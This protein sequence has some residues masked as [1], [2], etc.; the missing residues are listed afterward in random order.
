MGAADRWNLGE[1]WL[2]VC[3]PDRPDLEHFV[4]ACIDGGVDIVQLREKHLPDDQLVKRAALAQ[5]VCADRHVPFILND[6]PD[7]ATAID[8]DGVH[9][10]QQD[11]SPIAARRVMGH[12]A[13]I[14]LSTHA[15]EE[16]E[17]ALGTRARPGEPDCAGGPGTPNS[18]AGMAPVDYISAGPV[19]A[20]PT[21]PGRPGT[22]LGYIGEAVRRAPWSVWVTGGVDPT[23]VVD[24]V[25]AGARHFVVVRWLTEANDPKARA[26]MLRQ[27]I[28]ETVGMAAL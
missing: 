12:H 4:E 20:T 22:G 14:G 25:A 18:D 19:T 27:A 24:M 2:Y 8:A 1:R 3:T 28:D 13:I 17:T 9:I 21:K 26:R 5:R 7:L 15:A 23:T 10:G 6:R 16:L 11:M